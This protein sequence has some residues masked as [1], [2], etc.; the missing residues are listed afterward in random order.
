MRTSYG[1]LAVLALVAIAAFMLFMPMRSG[2]EDRL[3]AT[4]QTVHLHRGDTYAIPVRLE[5]ARQQVVT[6][7]SVNEG[8][9]RVNKRG[10]I[11]AVSAGSTDIHMLAEE[12]ARGVVHVEVVGS[13]VTS[14]ALSADV[15]NMEKGQVSGL[16]VVFNDTADE[17]LVEWL[18]ADE[19]VAVVDAMGRVTAVGGGKTRVIASTPGG[20]TASAEV[21]VHVD[22][23]ALHITPD[24]LTLGVG[25]TIQMG[26][27][28]FPDD[29]TD[30]I[31]RWGSDNPAV[32]TVADDGTLHAEGEGTAVIS[33][34]SA[35]GLGG[36]TIVKVESSASQFI[37]SPAAA[38]IERGDVLTLI[39]GFMTIDGRAEDSS[40]GH[41][42]QWTSSDPEVASVENGRVVALKSGTTR[43]TAA[44]DGMTAE[45]NLRVQVLVHEVRFTARELYLIREQTGNPIQLNASVSPEDADN[46]RLTYTT[47]NDLVA[48]VSPDGLVTLTGG[49]GTAVITATAEGGA[50][51]RFTINVVTE[52]PADLL[53]QSTELPADLLP[54]S[55]ELPAVTP[56]PD[57]FEVPVDEINDMPVDETLVP[58]LGPTPIPTPTPIAASGV[59]IDPDVSFEDIKNETDPNLDIFGDRIQ[60]PTPVPTAVP[61]RY[62][63]EDDYGDGD[64]DEFPFSSSM[65]DTDEDFDPDY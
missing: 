20:M 58:T 51:A 26:T 44:A 38:T 9:A 47:D 57:G 60:T 1:K 7:S 28:Y 16:K 13:P 43:I 30:E 11:T 54:Q 33:A 24:N 49:Y 31:V 22:G 40:A 45:C 17:K 37:V 10:V 34:F 15:L 6:Y 23:T 41:Y 25:S 46:A 39:P 2:T 62:D 3:Y 55:T 29:T 19:K 52:L 32:A 36:S 5:A 64:D 63:D 61:D 59:H 42:I 8:V 27:Y 21:N 48:T 12:G 50:Q 4:P 53:P 35:A 18:S 14:L 65:K 56:V